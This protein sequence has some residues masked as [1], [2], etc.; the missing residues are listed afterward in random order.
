MDLRHDKVYKIAFELRR[1]YILRNIVLAIK[2]GLL[3]CIKGEIAA[4]AFSISSESLS[5]EPQDELTI[6]QIP[7]L[8][9]FKIY[10]WSKIWVGP[11]TLSPEETFWCVVIGSL[12][13]FS[14]F[15]GAGLYINRYKQLNIIELQNNSTQV[16]FPY[17][18]VISRWGELETK[19]LSAFN[20]YSVGLRSYGL[21]ENCAGD[22]QNS[23][24]LTHSVQTGKKFEII[25]KR[26]VVKTKILTPVQNAPNFSLMKKTLIYCPIP[27]KNRGEALSDFECFLLNLNDIMKVCQEMDIKL[28]VK[29]KRRF[30]ET[31]EFLSDSQREKFERTINENRNIFRIGVLEHVVLEEQPTWIITSP[32]SSPL[33]EADLVLKGMQCFYY[34]NFILD[35]AKSFSNHLCIYGRHELRK[36]ISEWPGM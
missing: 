10:C 33:I 19:S 3:Q 14:F 9:E 13:F 20:S 25:K 23:Y 32:F 11:W 31:I 30:N 6:R 12:N 22:S 17:L 4:R 15:V 8:N 7:E 29:W 28:V 5:V 24:G 18:S 2:D 27:P 21:L 16:C 26:T 34:N 36:S 1:E 35:N